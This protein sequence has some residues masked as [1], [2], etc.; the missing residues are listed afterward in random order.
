LRQPR[1]RSTWNE[2][3]S[4]CLEFS[5]IFLECHRLILIVQQNHHDC[6]L[7]LW[8][9]DCKK[10]LYKIFLSWVWN[11]LVKVHSLTFLELNLSKMKSPTRYPN[12][13]GIDPKD[14]ECNWTSEMQVHQHAYYASSMSWNCS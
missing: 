9:L 12:T 11:S 10:E 3:Q 1:R 2:C 8:S 14:H 5:S 4:C 6:S 7:C 13:K